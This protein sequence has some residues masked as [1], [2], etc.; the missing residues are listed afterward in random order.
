[1]FKKPELLSPAGEPESLRGAVN[2]GADAV[3]LAAK[4]FGM[5][6]SPANFSFEELKQAS[7]FC[8]KR[9]VKL[10]LTCNIIPR[11][12]DIDAL[13]DFFS[14]IKECNLDALIIADVGIL[15]AAKRAL[16]DLDIHI[17]TQAGITNHLS[18]NAFYDLGAK[19]VVLARELSFDEIKIIREKSYPDLE[20]ETFIHGAM[21][22]SFSGRCLL[23]Q[24]LTNRDPNRGACAQPCRWKYSISEEHRPGQ[25][26]DI[27]EEDGGT[28]I[29]NSKD[30][31]MIQ[32]I[33]KLVE[34]GIDSFKIEGRAKSSYY[35]S[36]VTNAY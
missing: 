3:Y 12:E 29:L 28:Y 10:Y 19:R 8:H 17:S 16:P 11:T 7:D 21:C 18:A 25:Y 2:F 4:S 15:N 24:Y 14:A 30:L 22:V 32:Y 6:A 36:V 27:S 5:R 33:D 31:C 13:P 34:A 26:Y 9:G 23:S 35:T 20:I 1:M